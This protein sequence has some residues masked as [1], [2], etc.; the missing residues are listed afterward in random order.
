MMYVATV[1]TTHQPP[2]DTPATVQRKCQLFGPEASVKT[3]ITW[4]EGLSD[5]YTR[6]ST[7]ELCRADMFADTEVM[8]EG[9][10]Y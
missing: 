3:V 8:G 7:V 5:Q 10:M 9:G 6:V 2:I 1:E 4:A